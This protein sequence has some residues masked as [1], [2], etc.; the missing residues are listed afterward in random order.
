[1]RATVRWAAANVRIWGFTDVSDEHRLLA[2]ARRFDQDALGQIH[3]E[4]YTPLFRYALY[5]TGDRDL[6]EDVASE[7]FTRLLEG[8]RAG[9]GPTTT[10]AGW[11]FGVAARVVSDHFRRAYRAPTVGLDDGLSDF[12][13]T[14][15]G[16]T[17]EALEREE[18]L[19]AMQKLTEEQRHVIALRFGQ[20]MPIDQV[21]RM[22][23]KTEGAIKQLQ[24]RAVAALARQL[25]RDT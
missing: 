13:L 21:A 18:L 4:Y 3:D 1:M 11:L 12:D 17:V 6:A 22:L 16:L 9:T 7:V 20:G 15:S 19:L 10:L 14:P 24:A 2:R 23:G 8:L 25:K 5:R